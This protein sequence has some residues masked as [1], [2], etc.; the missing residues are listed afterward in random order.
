MCVPSE[1]WEFRVGGGSAMI[2]GV[3]AVLG[4][5]SRIW[6]KLEHL[7]RRR[8]FVGKWENIVRKDYS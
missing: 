4:G 6:L 8:Y 5:F 7:L 3:E 2:S 1:D